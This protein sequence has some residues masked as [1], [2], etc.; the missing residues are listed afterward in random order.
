MILNTTASG[1]GLSHQRNVV[2]IR[3]RGSV[4]HSIECE[5]FI[6]L[7]SA[8]LHLY[9]G[10]IEVKTNDLHKSSDY[11]ISTEIALHPSLPVVDVSNSH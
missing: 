5:T 6:V 4:L 7:S 9:V 3:N 2:A 1:R 10:E 8:T 11:I